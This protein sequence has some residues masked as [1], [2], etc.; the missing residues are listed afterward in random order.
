METIE[1]WLGIQ[2]SLRRFLRSR[3]DDETLVEDLAQD[4][5]VRVQQNLHELK[6]L[7]KVTPWIFRIAGNVVAD[8]YRKQQ[9][10][11]T[12][13]KKML[14]TATE[15]T[16][17]QQPEKTE[18]LAQWLPYAIQGLPE[19][20]REAVRLVDMEGM[21][22]KDLAEHLDISYSGARSRV[23]RGRQLLKEAVLDCCEV[24]TDAYGNILDYHA[25]TC[26]GEHC[27]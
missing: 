2:D 23:Q 6:E 16:A 25:R 22:Q 5:F 9:K 17:K 15:S 8:Y 24:K 3:L 13:R 27:D 12:S 18:L 20:Y 19:K 26:A 7:D 4:V 10:E 21:S 1:I 14:P 11:Q